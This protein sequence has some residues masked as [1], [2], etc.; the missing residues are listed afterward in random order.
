MMKV[1]TSL[2]QQGKHTEAEAIYR[3]TLRLKETVL[4]MDHPDTLASIM[5]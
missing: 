3:Q 4:G 1:A 2:G 5:T